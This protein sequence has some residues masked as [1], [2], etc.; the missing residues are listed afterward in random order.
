MRLA[1][2]G[3]SPRARQEKLKN[4][5]LGIQATD[6]AY[7]LYLFIETVL[8]VLFAGWPFPVPRLPRVCLSN[9]HIQEKQDQ[10][11][12]APHPVPSA[13]LSA[14]HWCGA[15]GAHVPDTQAGPSGVPRGTLHKTCRSIRLALYPRP[16]FVASFTPLQV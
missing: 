16:I 6:V 3:G 8:H 11:P 12:P 10:Q 9:F 15:G 5:E 2:I 7:S 1:N 4:S 13:F 14:G